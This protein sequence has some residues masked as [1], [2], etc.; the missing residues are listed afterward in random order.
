ML[1]GVF[2]AS[3]AWQLYVAA[4]AFRYAPRFEQLFSSLGAEL[5]LITRVLLATYRF[6]L[7]IP[8]VFALL[9]ARAIRR[10]AHSAAY[11]GVLSASCVIA[12]FVMQAWLYEG[13]FSPLFAVI[14]QIG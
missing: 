14:K 2:S 8:L 9:A 7:A 6:W 3:I 1:I 13:Y 12:G 5:P 4:T 10:P 11:L